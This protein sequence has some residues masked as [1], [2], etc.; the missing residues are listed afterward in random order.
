MGWIPDVPRKDHLTEDRIRKFRLE[1]GEPRALGFGP[2]DLAL[3][4]TG[5]AEIDA[6]RAAERHA[7][8]FGEP[9]YPGGWRKLQ[10]GEDY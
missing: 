7:G 2:E 10:P 1:G 8:R 4:S 5:D 6:E 9:R 3:E